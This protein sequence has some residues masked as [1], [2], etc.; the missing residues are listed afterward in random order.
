[1][2]MVALDMIPFA[3]YLPLTLFSSVRKIKRTTMELKTYIDQ[4]VNEHWRTYDSENI[5]DLC[6]A[7]LSEVEVGKSKT[8]DVEKLTNEE[9]KWILFDFYNSGTDT[10]STVLT[11][12]VLYLTMH[13][14]IQEECYRAINDVIGDREPNLNDRLQLQ[15]VEAVIYETLRIRPPVFMGF[16]MPLPH[17]AVEDA[18]LGS[19]QVPKDTI[20]LANSYAIHTDPKYWKNPLDFDPKL[21]FIDDD[22]SLMSPKS[23]L[24]FGTGRRSCLGEQLAR[25]ELFLAVTRLLQK[26]QLVSVPG[27]LYNDPNADMDL[28]TPSLFS[29]RVVPRD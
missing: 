20:L 14:D 26:V 23:F 19:F 8:G 16:G 2:N 21:H 17:A 5:R 12:I 10:T 3:R 13:P 9:L 28:A 27:E 29:I 7:L 24:P 1:M 25:K 15:L 4:E 18:P 6:D 22:G 11:W